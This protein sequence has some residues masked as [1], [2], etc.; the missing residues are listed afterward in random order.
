MYDASDV[1]LGYVVNECVG[2]DC[3]VTCMMGAG[4]L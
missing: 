4:D 1:F 3:K 2:L